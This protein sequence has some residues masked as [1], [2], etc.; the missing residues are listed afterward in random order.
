LPLTYDEQSIGP[1]YLGD[2]RI[3]I[4]SVVHTINRTHESLLRYGRDVTIGLRGWLESRGAATGIDSVLF[5]EVGEF[6]EDGHWNRQAGLRTVRSELTYPLGDALP[7]QE[8]AGN[9][10]DQVL[11]LEPE[12]A[13]RLNLGTNWLNA[14]QQTAVLDAKIVAD[15]C[16]I[17]HF[18]GAIGLEAAERV[19]ELLGPLIGADPTSLREEISRI[20][21][22]R[23][24][25]VHSIGPSL[26][27]G[28]VISAAYVAEA[29][30][31][32]LVSGQLTQSSPDSIRTILGLQRI[33]R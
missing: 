22:A 12:A 29:L 1:A 33:V 32:I 11:G 31:E 21:G 2:L 18:A 27:L 16:A 26:S 20:Y 19:A 7:S 10:L 5:E 30:R 13:R 6:F 24:Q 28:A 25:V 23:N 17:E 14:A 9:A 4:P 3:E 8:S 15:W